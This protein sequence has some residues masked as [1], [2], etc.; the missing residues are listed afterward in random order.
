MYVKNPAARRGIRIISLS[1][2]V[3]TGILGVLLL[4]DNYALL[5]LFAAVLTLLYFLSGIERKKI[6]TRRLILT[7]ILTAL[8]V[9]GR[10]IPVFKPITAVTMIAGVYLGAEAGF[11]VGSLSALVSNFYFGHGP[12]TP[13]QML[14]WGLIGLLSGIFSKSLKKY[15]VFL[16]SFAVFGGVFYSIVMDAWNVMFYEGSF[17]AE[18][19]GAA[20]LTALPFTVLYAVSNVIFIAVLFRPFGKKLERIKI[21]YGI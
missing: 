17:S 18:M 2:F 13:F 19:F 9:L 7:S 11:T 14:S 15:P 20:L 12:W 3:I 10:F 5:S 6:G 21:K 16:Y 1:L 8:S 4:K